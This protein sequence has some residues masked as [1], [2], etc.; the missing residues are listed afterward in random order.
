MTKTEITADITTLIREAGLNPADYRIAVLA[1][2]VAERIADS[3][4]D[5]YPHTGELIENW[6]ISEADLWEGLGWEWNESIP[7]TDAAGHAAY[8][9]A[10][11]LGAD[12][13]FGRRF[14]AAECEAAAWRNWR[15]AA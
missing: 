2:E 7:L 8:D 11:S 14:W 6:G 12:V 9:V 15:A 5:Y 1:R 4:I 3:E 10:E 13:N